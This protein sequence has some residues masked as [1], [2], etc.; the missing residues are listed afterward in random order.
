MTNHSPTG[1]TDG[2]GSL[3]ASAEL[4]DSRRKN[5]VETKITCPFLGSAAQE[6]LLPVR[7]DANNPLASIEDVRKLGNCGGGDLGDLLVLFAKG[8][9][10]LMRGPSGKLTE[11]VPAELF[12]LELP[13]SQGSHPGHSGILET[14]PNEPGSG[15]TSLQNFQRLANRATQDGFIR[16]SD[17]GRFI[18]ENL[19]RDPNSKVAI[20]NIAE[21]L[22]RDVAA[23]IR[24]GGIAL[25]EEL[26]G[27]RGQAVE[28]HR[29]LEVMLTKLLAE[30]NLVGSAG[31]FGLMM[32]FLTN[33]PRTIILKTRDGEPKLPF[34]SE[35]ALSLQEVRGMFIDKRFPAGWEAWK[36]S[37]ADWVTH[38]TALVI[39]AG[40]EYRS[41]KK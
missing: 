25:W 4:A 35:P 7:G 2:G 12:S 36:K 26:F 37:R 34:R 23:G 29:D 27:A 32:A 5:I 18:G 33:S 41:L 1:T 11:R 20:T 22:A 9:H 28:A 16:R 10:S 30:D 6:G 39:S 14:D 8:N 19:V 3:H 38:T 24:A 13:G 40:A 15:K 31:E 21:L 17:I